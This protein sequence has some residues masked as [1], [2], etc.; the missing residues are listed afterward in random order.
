[1]ETT[2]IIVSVFYLFIVFV[3]LLMA[4]KCMLSHAYLSIHEK[5]ASRKWEEIEPKI[6]GLEHWRQHFCFCLQL[7]L[8]YFSLQHLHL[9]DHNNK[10]M[11]RYDG[12]DIRTD[13]TRVKQRPGFCY[14]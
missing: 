13:Y 8:S 1:L 3:S 4:Y 9:K 10:L 7:F 14:L 5:A 12:V 2:A 6:H 11:Q